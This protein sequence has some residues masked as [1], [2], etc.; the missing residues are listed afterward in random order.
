MAEEHTPLCEDDGTHPPGANG[1]VRLCVETTVTTDD[2]VEKRIPLIR[3]SAQRVGTV[4]RKGLEMRTDAIKRDAA[5]ADRPLNT[6]PPH[7]MAICAW[8]LSLCWCVCVF[9]SSVEERCRDNFHVR[10]A[11]DFSFQH[12]TAIVDLEGPRIDVQS[13]LSTMRD[14]SKVRTSINTYAQAT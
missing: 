8:L 7:I 4:V 13:L 9:M 5:L 1:S 14:Y 11:R 6:S 12:R 3:E 10:L 2:D